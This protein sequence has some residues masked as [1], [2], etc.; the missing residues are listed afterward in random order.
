MSP[1]TASPPIRGLLLDAG[2]VLYGPVG[3]RW[4]PRFDFERL[5][6]AFDPALDPAR[7]P[8]RFAAAVEA[9]DRFLD[10][11]PYTPARDDY[12]RAVLAVLGLA[13][14]P[15]LLLAELDRALDVPHLELFPE[16]IGVL[17]EIRRRGLP[18]A[19]VSDS[20]SRKEPRIDWLGLDPYVQIWVI[21]EDLGCS[22]PDPRMF[23]AGSDGIGVPPAECLFVDDGPELVEAA[24]ALGYQGAA[25][26]RTLPHPPAKVPWIDSLEGVLDLLN[27]PLNQPRARAPR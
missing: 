26:G 7:D 13:D 6:A 12:H 19:I 9:G 1:P 4:N 20:W 23:A 15:A 8:A 17:D 22:K 18:I 3:G 2:G 24:V 11:V 21:S 5:V 10:S 16:V 14:P 27:Q 25:L